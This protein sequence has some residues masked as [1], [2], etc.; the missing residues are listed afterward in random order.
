[1]GGKGRAPSDSLGLG[2]RQKLVREGMPSSVW[3]L[4][5]LRYLQDTWSDGQ[6]WGFGPR[7]QGKCGEGI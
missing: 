1:M 6:R 4:Q 7:A 5:G 2:M 3:G